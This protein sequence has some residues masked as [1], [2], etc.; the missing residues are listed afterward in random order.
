MSMQVICVSLHVVHGAVF[1][2]Q[3]NLNQ[4]LHRETVFSTF[5]VIWAS[6]SLQTEGEGW[7]QCTAVTIYSFQIAAVS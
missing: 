4:W 5:A 1:F 2:C 3:I 7:N 6:I